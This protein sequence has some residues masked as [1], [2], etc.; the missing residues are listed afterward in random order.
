MLDPIAKRYPP[1][2]RNQPL[3]KEFLDNWI[4]KWKDDEYRKY[5]QKLQG[6]NVR[7][8]HFEV[9][10]I[11]IMFNNAIENA[12]SKE[13]ASC[14]IG[15]REYFVT[16]LKDFDRMDWL[17][18]VT[19]STIKF[20]KWK[21]T[22]EQKLK[23]LGLA[24]AKHPALPIMTWKLKDEQEKEKNDLSGA[25]QSNVVSEEAIKAQL[26]SSAPA[27]SRSTQS[28]A[29]TSL[30]GEPQS[31]NNSFATGITIPEHARRLVADMPKNNIAKST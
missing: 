18:I 13:D 4:S 2:D 21:P 29:T 16:Q 10:N 7:A 5:R 26:P 1:F 22:V 11:N 15:L 6:T 31:P 8:S 27:A 23:D 25:S 19:H 9:L 24:S 30:S 28:N 12:I 17:D 14:I 3:T 20:I